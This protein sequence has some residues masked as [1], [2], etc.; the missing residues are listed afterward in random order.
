MTIARAAVAGAA[1]ATLLIAPSAAQAQA[2][3][4]IKIAPVVVTVARGPGRS[5]LQSPF[6]ITVVEPDS[7]RPGQKHSSMD[8]SLALVPGVAAVSRNNPA[9]DPRLSIRGFGARSAFGV[10]GVRILRDGMPITLPDGQTPL[11]YLS[12]ESVGRIEILRGAASALYGNASGGVVDLMSTPSSSPLSIDARQ[13]LG[14]NALSRSVIAA[15]G[16]SRSTSYV[17]DLEYTRTDGARRHSAQRATSGFART[18]LNAGRS[19][20]ALSIL[21][22]DNPLSENPG[23]LTLDEMRSN[24]LQ[25][26]ALS[27]RRDAKKAVRQIQVGASAETGLSG[28]TLSLS[29]Y[30]GSRSL[31]NPLTFGIVE[32]GRHSYG[33]SASARGDAKLFGV[34]HSMIAGVDFQSQNDLRRN[35]VTCIDTVPQTTPTATCPYPGEER[36]AVTLDQRELVSSVGV[37]ASDQASLSDRVSVSGGVR[38]DRVR[39]KVEDRLIGG[40]N[41]NDSGLRNLGAVSPVAGIVFRFAPTQSLY[42]NISSA[43]ETP[44]ATELGNH[45]DGSAGIN[46]DLNPQRSTTIETGA[47]GWLTSVVR[48]DAALFDTRVRDELVP[49]EIPQ[50]NGRRF[51]RNAGR[52]SRRGA[53]A[54]VDITAGPVAIMS[55]YTY[56]HFRFARYSAGGVDYSGNE[57]PGIPSHRV[58]SAARVALHSVFVVLET[59]T[60]TRTFV[61]DANTSRA[62][63][64]SVANARAGWSPSLLPAR[65]SVTVGAQNIF[66]RVYASSIAVNAARGKYYEPA[67]R[68]NFFVGVSVGGV[69]R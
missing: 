4:A 49:F 40:S 54:S 27:L 50:S 43:F 38:A 11:D 52:T 36:G 12:L 60:A 30:G 39:F 67:S 65:L 19:D 34:S 35:Y 22:L 48:Y 24:S 15:S 17:S 10:R 55:A 37:Y 20:F 51:F 9:Q 44:T 13:W 25:S 59:E 33:S 69:A 2:D 64:Y 46:P 28:V 7:A 3:T 61:D 66:D 26:D 32:I 14:S 56:S 16:S 57:I 58:Q 45:E 68:R 6:A 42:A 18:T 21:G 31:D 63:G 8:E 1:M 29:G 23:A 47:K 62:P 41:P 5:I 53:E